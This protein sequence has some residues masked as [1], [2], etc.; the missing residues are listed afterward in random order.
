MNFYLDEIP[1]FQ[2]EVVCN[3]LLQNCRCIFDAKYK[4]QDYNTCWIVPAWP[5]PSK[6]DHH[7]NLITKVWPPVTGSHWES[8]SF[9]KMSGC[10]AI[11]T[12]WKSLSWNVQLWSPVSSGPAYWDVQDEFNHFTGLVAGILE[13]SIKSELN[14]SIQFFYALYF[15]L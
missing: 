11:G 2:L 13:E 10:F 7:W 9:I 6:T 8:L 15:Q 12:W 4:L 3:L 14:Q 5:Q 1:V